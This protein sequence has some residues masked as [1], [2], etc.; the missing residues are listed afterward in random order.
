[1]R[2]DGL[3]PSRLDGGGGGGIGNGT[4]VPPG[5]SPDPLRQSKQRKQSRR[6]IHEWLS[7]LDEILEDVGAP[8]GIGG[9][10]ALE[11]NSDG[12]A[13]SGDRDSEASVSGGPSDKFRNQGRKWI[14][15]MWTGMWIILSL[16]PASLHLWGEWPTEAS[17]GVLPAVHATQPYV[18]L[19][20]VLSGFV[21]LCFAI[22]TKVKQTIVKKFE[23]LQ[24]TQPG[25]EAP[26]TKD[27]A[28]YL[29][30]ELMSGGGRK[31]VRSSSFEPDK[32]GKDG[33][34]IQYPNVGSDSSEMDKDKVR[35]PRSAPVAVP[36]SAS[37]AANAGTAT[38]VEESATDNP[39]MNPA[40]S[41][42]EM[43]KRAKQKKE[44]KATDA[45]D[46]DEFSSPPPLHTLRLR[47]SSSTPL[48]G[49]S[50]GNQLNNIL[51]S[52]PT[53]MATTA[54]VDE[55]LRPSEALFA[56]DLLPPATSAPPR[57]S[58]H[59][60]GDDHRSSSDANH[61]ITYGSDVHRGSGTDYGSDGYGG[62]GPNSGDK[63]SPATNRR[64]RS[65][66]I[67][68]LM[69]KQDSAISSLHR[70]S[71]DSRSTRNSATGDDQEEEEEGEY[72]QLMVSIWVS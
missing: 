53:N 10:P 2:T 62:G 69:V 11:Q 39:L 20:F 19:Y 54:E 43:S 14:Q 37:A 59:D 18:G 66:F 32:D 13:V 46:A 31:Q 21:S 38:H 27:M 30:K 24:P 70:D 42:G 45:T 4:E 48:T 9:T 57:A 47:K 56:G 34:P 55:A 63:V 58:H 52:T 23:V 60:G 12:G 68:R 17:C 35:M 8:P 65:K 50:P 44:Q 1:M 26:T 5:K 29:L 3:D 41:D 36:R 15:V 61:G 16:L 22:T 28:K 64:A 7:K 25:E 33:F 71:A 49:S 72:P 6:D 67:V 40:L 51:A